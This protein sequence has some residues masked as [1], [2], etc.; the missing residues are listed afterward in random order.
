[1]TDKKQTGTEQKLLADTNLDESRQEFIQHMERMMGRKLTQQEINMAILQAEQIRTGYL[2]HFRQML[3]DFETKLTARKDE[4]EIKSAGETFCTK[5]KDSLTQLEEVLKDGKIPTILGSMESLLKVNSP[6]WMP[7]ALGGLGT[8]DQRCSHSFIADDCRYSLCRIDSCW[9]VPDGQE[10]RTPEGYERESSL[11]FFRS[12]KEAHHQP[13]K[14]MK[15]G[16]MSFGETLY[17]LRWS[18]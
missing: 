2:L 6:T 13:A 7:A 15:A 9:Q 12:Q 18:K 17:F 16:S 11:V 8:C 3:D 1:M 14:C 5:L 10:K 4:V